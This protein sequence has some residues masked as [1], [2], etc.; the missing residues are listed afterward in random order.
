VEILAVDQR[1]DA[2][3]DN[4]VDIKELRSVTLLVTPH[5]ANLLDLGQNKGTLHLA[6]R[7]LQD[8][9]DSNIRPATLADLRFRHEKPWEEK[10][11]GL[12]S[13]L[14][15]GLAQ[16]RATPAPAP[17][18]TPAPVVAAP[19]PA[20]ALAPVVAAPMPAPR[21]PRFVAIYRGPSSLRYERLDQSNDSEPGAGVRTNPDQAVEQEVPPQATRASLGPDTR[22][23]ARP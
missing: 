19:T 2:P 3:A 5:Q 13:V 1:I 14:G 10:A 16:L 15:A 21:R 4:K 7:N 12:L 18:P 6:L 23:G 17:T 22:L 9:Q 8:D 20:P 11:K